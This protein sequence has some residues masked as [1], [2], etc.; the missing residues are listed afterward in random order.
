[1]KLRCLDRVACAAAQIPEESVRLDEACS[2]SMGCRK[3]L[4]NEP[5][6][7]GQPYQHVLALEVCFLNE[8]IIEGI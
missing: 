1:M 7:N 5:V 8:S 3:Q 6:W 2:Q 4:L